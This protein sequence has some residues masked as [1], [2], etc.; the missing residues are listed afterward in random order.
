MELIMKDTFQDIDK[1]SRQKISTMIHETV[2][3]A[4]GIY[5]VPALCKILEERSIWKSKTI[6]YVIDDQL[7][8]GSI[9]LDRYNRL[10][11]REYIMPS[12]REGQLPSRWTIARPLEDARK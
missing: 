5:E 11:C 12:A 7:D 10:C 1:V 4:S 2:R 8:F 9:Y 3:A 6:H